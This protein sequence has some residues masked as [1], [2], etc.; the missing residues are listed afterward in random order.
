MNL[1]QAYQEQV[2]SALKAA[3]HQPIRQAAEILC[4]A[5]REGGL[6]HIVGTD[7]HSTLAAQDVIYRHGNFAAINGMYDPSFSVTH[8]ASRSMY[9][10]ELHQCGT[11]LM[12]YYRNLSRGDAIIVV[13]ASAKSNACCEVVEKAK[14]MGLRVVLL[15]SHRLFAASDFMPQLVCADPQHVLA[16]AD[17][18][19]DNG[20]ESSLGGWT[21][22]LLNSYILNLVF[23]QTFDIMP[24]ADRWNCFYTAN[25]RCRN[26][27][28]VEKYYDRVKHI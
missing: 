11:F 16:A 13:D 21:D 18:L 19:L 27:Q 22:T 12:E 26:E 5:L 28:L 20:A 4:E 1:Q 15:Y 17:V 7:M 2:Q 6:I 14:E 25:G 9:I 3:Q 8:G 23:L 24:E 10:E